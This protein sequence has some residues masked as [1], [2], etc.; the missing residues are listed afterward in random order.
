MLNQGVQFYISIHA[1]ARGA[2]CIPSVCTG[3][4]NISIHAPA[5]GASLLI[6][7]NCPYKQFQFT[8]LREG[9]L[10][11]YRLTFHSIHFNS[12]PCERGF[13]FLLIRLCSISYF[14]SRPC[15]RG[16]LAKQSVDLQSKRISIH[17]PARGASLMLLKQLDISTISIHAPARGASVLGGQAIHENVRFQFTPLREGLHSVPSMQPKDDIISI[18]APAR[19]ASWFVCSSS[20]R[21][22][23][24][25]HAPARGASEFKVCNSSSHIIS[26]HAPARGASILQYPNQTGLSL[27]QFTPLREGLPT[28]LPLE[29]RRMNF[30]SRPCER[31]FTVLHV[32]KDLLLISIHAPARGASVY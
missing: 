32:K 7:K 14:N 29:E 20:S 15:E 18:H 22:S 28:D 19:G 21:S 10:Y 26:I 27:F 4:W 3:R 11:R 25:I 31:G 9:L 16:F 2:S 5:R 6:Q 13:N 30:N 23:I 24:S 8:P 12:R 1:P 17:A